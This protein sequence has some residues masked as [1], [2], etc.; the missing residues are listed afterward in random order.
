M[1]KTLSFIALMLVS[2]AFHAQEIVK[3]ELSKQKQTYWDFN[4]TQ[5]QSRGK[6]YVDPLVGETEDEHGKWIYY[7]RLGEI[8]EVRHY[9]KGML[10]GKVTMFY[11][12]GKKR[13]EGFFKWDLQDSIYMEW[14]ET[15]HVKVEGEYAMGEAVSHWKYY[16][17][18]G[19]LKSV[20]ET[21]GEDN[22]LWE[23]YLPDSLHTQTINE[24]EGELTTFYTT[25]AVKEWYNYKS[26]LKDGQFEEL[27]IYGYPTLKGSFKEGEK[28]G[29][30]EYAYYTGD[31][32][33]IS[34]YKDGV[35]DG[36]YQYF[37]DNGELNV[38]GQYKNGNK[39]GEWVWYTNKGTRDMQGSFT[40]G[41]Q[42]GDWTYWFPTGE[43]SY[44]A[45]YDADKRTGQWTY[46]YLNGKKFK[47][48]TFDNDLKN[49][50][51][52]TWYEDE[53]LLMEGSYLNG[54]ED[55]E[56]NNYWESGDLKNKA[57]FKSGKLDGEWQSHFPNGKPHVIGEYSDD[58]KIGEWQTFFDNGKPKDIVTYK[59]FKKKS[60]VESLMKGHVTM[61]S[62]LHGHSISYSDKDFRM[63]EEGNYKEG[64]KDGEWTAYH[65][66][67]KMA[68]VVSN[69]KDGKLDG[70]M[71]QYS[72]R[73][74]LM[75]SIDY[76]DGLKHGSFKVYDK[77]GKVVNERKYE[78]GMQII[79]GR[80][81]SSGSFTPG[82]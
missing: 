11:P 44:Y 81:N 51:W 37:Y 18:D 22:Y 5:I 62:K 24:G 33:K 19:R 25:G 61:E 17:R 60:K 78:F 45:K 40:E 27:S 65:P 30:W 28:D 7:D 59:V 55:G 4:K 2:F 9:Y 16:Y 23:F 64:L 39:E 35:L 14:F 13:Q 71:K 47:E 32:E 56:W 68:A 8:E 34:N 63:T 36:K 77:R 21:K 1:I 29:E 50:E 43:I 82:G 53:T 73:G 49:G 80:T 72:R 74:K 75:S 54:K 58:L 46:F 79:E 66:G 31:K 15:G 76:K 52:K 57:T 10:S 41:A 3:E 20:E 42:H 69:Y 67:G 6:C 26:G 48:G 70:T 12:N 38:N